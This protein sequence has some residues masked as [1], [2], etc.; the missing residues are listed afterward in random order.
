MQK[1]ARILPDLIKELKNII[2]ALEESKIQ[3]M[4]N[5]NERISGPYLS[6]S[7]K[8]FRNLCTLNYPREID[9]IYTY[10]DMLL[11]QDIIN[12]S[13]KEVLENSSLK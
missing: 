8:T 3:E 1:S 10:R 12:Y 6:G 11:N 13:V 4:K 2:N 5:Y 7:F 9:L